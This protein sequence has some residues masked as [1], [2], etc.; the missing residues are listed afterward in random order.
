MSAW[1]HHLFLFLIGSSVFF[2]TCLLLFSRFG[3]Q[4][5]RLRMLQQRLASLQANE[6]DLLSLTHER[7]PAMQTLQR[8]RLIRRSLLAIIIM[9]MEW[10]LMGQ[11]VLTML[12]GLA[13]IILPEISKRRREHERIEKFEEQLPEVLEAIIRGLRVGYPLMETLR[14]VASEMEDP[15][16]GEFGQTCDEIAMGIELRHAL[17]NMVLRVPCQPLMTMTTTMNLQRET[18]GNL[19]ESLATIS[20]VIRSRFRFQRQVR[21]LTAESRLSGILMMI[22]PF[23]LF[24][25]MTQ[26][27]PGYTDILLHDPVGQQLGL[28]ALVLILIGGFWMQNILR[29]DI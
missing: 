19:A 3:V 4:Q 21:I 5:Q 23:V 22:I 15:I 10:M 20:K 8:G 9:F 6:S 14:M 25:M 12:T 18:G 28:A 24:G 7:L 17:A 1:A 27:S 26:L 16:A 29:I 11:L 13:I 2:I